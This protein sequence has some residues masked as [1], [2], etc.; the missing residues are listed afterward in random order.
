MGQAVRSSLEDDIAQG[1]VAHTPH[2]GLE[3][4]LGQFLLDFDDV[5]LP[6]GFVNPLERLD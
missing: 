3:E 4:A 5:L 6:G 1:F 2:A